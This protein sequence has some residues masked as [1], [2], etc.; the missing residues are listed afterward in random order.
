MKILILLLALA[1]AHYGPRVDRTRPLSWLL[2]VIDTLIERGARVPMID[3]VVI[4][5]VA[6]VGGGGLSVLAE[7]VGGDAVWAL[8]ALA[9]LVM[10][11]GPRDLDRDVDALVATDSGEGLSIMADDSAHQAGMQV[12]AAALARWFGVIFWFVLLGIPG[13]LLY[14]LTEQMAQRASA[15]RPLD[16]TFRLRFFLEWPVLVLMMVASALT[17]DFDRVY[18]AWHQFRQ[19]HAVGSNEPGEPSGWWIHRGV[20]AELA[21]G[22]LP[23]GLDQRGGVQLAHHFVWRILILWL[24]VLSVLLL[25]GALA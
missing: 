14:R 15:D 2:G 3:V 19:P 1:M 16:G 4:L 11:L 9:V 13:I 24:V 20:L 10:G 12:Y 18:Q 8:L 21:D 17:N 7:A 6:L 23:E 5:A 22:V 25:V